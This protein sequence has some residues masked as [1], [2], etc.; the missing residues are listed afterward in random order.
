[1][2]AELIASALNARR[3]RPGRWIAR[4]PAHDDRNPSLSIA[5]A[6][7]K[8]LV[9]CFA[10]CSQAD[11]IEA[12]RARGLWPEEKREWLPKPDYESQRRR[13]ELLHAAE[14]WQQGLILRLEAARRG[15]W[16]RFLEAEASGDDAGQRQAATDL[17]L[18][19]AR[20]RAVARPRGPDLLGLY[21][22]ARQRFPR[23]VAELINDVR[24]DEE[25]ARQIAAAC[26][27][28]MAAANQIARG[29]AR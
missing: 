23:T 8:V 22:E 24:Q 19:A 2:N 5:E 14:F 4:C 27:A 26:V 12:L 13:L 17:L 20:Q 6:S 9:H 21:S 3:T 15:A 10:G 29:G 11:V 7:G 25:H 18:L 28:L 16:R 1:M